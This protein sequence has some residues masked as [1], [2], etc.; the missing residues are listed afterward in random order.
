M[1]EPK[2]ATVELKNLET[3]IRSKREYIENHSDDLEQARKL[4]ADC[5]QFSQNIDKIKKGLFFL[6][7][8]NIELSRRQ[9]SSRYTDLLAEV[10]RDYYGEEDSD[11]KDDTAAD[12]AAIKQAAAKAEAAKSTDVIETKPEMLAA[13]QEAEAKKEAEEQTELKAEQANDSQGDSAEPAE[14][15]ETDDPDKKGQK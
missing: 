1:T 2:N 7:V 14:P 10:V 9:F 5:N 6:T 11:T 4:I 3:S 15:A 13:K 12:G 8:D